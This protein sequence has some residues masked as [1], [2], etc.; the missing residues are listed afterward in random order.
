[1]KKKRKKNIGLPPGTAMYT[2]QKS[3]LLIRINYVE[4]NE[5]S[6]KEELDQK[7]NRV[8]LHPSNLNLVQWY[9]IRGLHDEELINKIGAIFSM[10]PLAIED[11]VDVMQRPLFTEYA[12]GAFVSMKSVL[13]DDVSYKITT[14]SV[15]FYFG[16]GFVISFQEN[17]DDLFQ[18]IRSR[19]ANE[20][21][22]IRHK[23]SDYL[24]YALIDYLVDSYFLIIERISRSIEKLEEDISLRPEEVE[25]S[26][27]F[28]LR[29]EVQRVRK[30]VTPLREA[31]LQFNRSDLPFIESQTSVF[32]RDV[33]DHTIQIIDSI[34]NQRDIL[35]GLQDLYISEISL[36]MNQVM[37]FLTIITALFVPL[38]FLAGLYG[39]NFEYIPELKYK[40]GYFVLL[41][42]MAII[43][44]GLLWNF[45]RKKWL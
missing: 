19:L 17:E 5:H 40:Y 32:I 8:L 28:L 27:I 26:R 36:K 22:R 15:S 31:L 39:M 29:K 24:T 9:D 1:M 42:V 20:Q 43:A 34:D 7:E 41:G 16:E 35:A 10:H 3:D 45:K 38:S 18:E 33:S 37:Q 2:G 25:K 14:Q 44:I 30:R 6:Y 4:F 23:K 13:F 21:S 12:S 11:A